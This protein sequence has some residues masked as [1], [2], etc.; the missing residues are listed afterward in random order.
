M[1]IWCKKQININNKLSETMVILLSTVEVKKHSLW[2]YPI[3][4]TN[5]IC[6]Y[7]YILFSYFALCLL[8]FIVNFYFYTKFK[9]TIV[10]HTKTKIF[11]Q[12]SHLVWIV[13]FYFLLFI[14]FFFVITITIPLYNTLWPF[15]KCGQSHIL[16]LRR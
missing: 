10:M 2:I 13:L 1:Q 15:V 7:I 12:L 11:S 4:Y 6:K 9:K 8:L 3:A 16:H 14:Y 5:D